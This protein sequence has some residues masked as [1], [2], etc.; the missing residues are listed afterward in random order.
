MLQRP[1][2]LTQ[3]HSRPN[4]LQRPNVL[5]T[6]TRHWP[7]HRENTIP[8]RS[9]QNQSSAPHTGH[10]RTP[11]TPSSSQGEGKRENAMSG[12]LQLHPIFPQPA[13]RSRAPR[14]SHHL[15]RNNNRRQPSQLQ[16]DNHPHL[17]QHN[18]HHCRN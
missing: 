4:S 17:P 3:Q 7:G 5:S 9:T 10:G 8:S 1:P 13:E 18:R 15:T 11:P 16:V 6:I 14:A 2:P 12:L